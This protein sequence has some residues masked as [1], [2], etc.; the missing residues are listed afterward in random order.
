[1]CADE[2]TISRRL[3]TRDRINIACGQDSAQLDSLLR[4]W[5]GAVPSGRVLEL[6]VS[7]ETNQYEESLRIVLDKIGSIA[8]T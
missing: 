4:E 2:Q 6:D 7:N 5:L 1:L 8:S 3:S